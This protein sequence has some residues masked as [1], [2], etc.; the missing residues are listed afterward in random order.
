MAALVLCVRL[1]GAAE[2]AAP[3]A[4]A[5]SCG[6]IAAQEA[7]GAQSVA[8]C[9]PWSSPLCMRQP[10]QATAS[11]ASTRARAR[12]PLVV[13]RWPGRSLA[14][15]TQRRRP[16]AHP[17]TLCAPRASCGSAGYR[18]AWE[19]TAPPLA[20]SGKKITTVMTFLPFPPNEARLRLGRRMKVKSGCGPGPFGER[21]SLDAGDD[22]SKC[23]LGPLGLPRDL[24]LRAT[25]R[26]A[27]RCRARA[28]LLPVL[29]GSLIGALKR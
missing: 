18:S 12:A 6:A 4:L 19:A 2:W 23:R 7:G 15:V 22:V 28:S 25:T 14:A 8:G 29:D 3:S 17:A 24:L 13:R 16:I 26:C 1:A 27:A 20:G 5:L 10:G 21:V 11:R 9:A